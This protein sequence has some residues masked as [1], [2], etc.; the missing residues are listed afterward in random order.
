MVFYNISIIYKIMKGG[1]K[2]NICG[3]SGGKRKT[4]RKYTYRNRLKHKR[5]VYKGGYNSSKTENKSKRHCSYS[6]LS[7]PPTSKKQTKRGGGIT[8]QPNSSI[9]IPPNFLHI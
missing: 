6:L 9:D 2:C 3:N 8:I 1:E 4:K 7:L 5:P